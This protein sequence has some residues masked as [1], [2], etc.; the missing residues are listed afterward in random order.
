MPRL[1]IAFLMSFLLA[2]PLMGQR[3]TIDSLSRVLPSVQGTKRVDVLNDLSSAHYDYDSERGLE[4]ARQARSLASELNY[5]PGLRQAITYEGFYYF[6][7]GDFTRA[8]ELYRESAGVKGDPDEFQGYNLVMIGNVFRALAEYDSAK[9]NYDRAINVLA[10]MNASNDLAFAYKNLGRLYVMQWKNVD[11]EQSF[12]KALTLY[13]S[14][15]RRYGIADIYLDLAQLSLHNSD[16]SRSAKF[17][18]DGCKIAED[19]QHEYLKTICLLRRGELEF[20]LG[21]YADALRSYFEALG[22]LET[23][24]LT[25]LLAQLY[26]NIG[27]VYRAIGQNDVALKYYEESL[28]ISER[29][30]TKY[31]IARTYNSIAVIYRS[32]NK[33]QEA[34]EFVNKSLAIRDQIHDEHGA[35][36]SYNARGVIYYQAKNYNKALEDFG[37]AFAI[38]SKIKHRDGMS[39]TLYN[40]SLVYLDQKQFQKAVDY[41]MR[42]LA[43]E[44]SIGNKYS[45]GFS[46][47][48]LG[49]LYTQL[50]KFPQAEAHLNR[51]EKIAKEIRSN[52]L[53]MN[54]A[55]FWSQYFD[56]RNNKALA[57]SYYQL[58][59]SIHDSIYHDI[60]A[61]KLAELQALYQMEK[62]DQEIA[63][64]SQEKVNRE[65]EIQLQRS[66]IN[67][68]NIL[69]ASVITGLV[70]VSLLAY[71]TYR[72]SKRIRKANLSITEQKE[73]IQAQSEELMEASETIAEINRKLEVKIEERTQAL[74]QAYKELDTFFYRSSHDFRRPL[75]TFL[76][77][78]EVAKVT[79]KDKAALELF[80]KVRET[81]SNLDK[82]LVKLQSISDVGSQQLFYKEVFMKEIF[83]T[84]CDAF[85]D[86]LHRK[87]IK[88]SID[89]SLR[90]PFI[91]YPAMVR[92]IVE[93]LV[94]NAI[95]FSGVN[96]P[97][98]K[99]KVVENG[100]YI[101]I[102]FQDNGQ[103]IAKEYQEQVFDMYFRGNERS[104]G[105]GLGL[106]I[107]KKAVEKLDGSITLSS[108]PMVGSTF[109]VMLPIRK[110]LG[111]TSTVYNKVG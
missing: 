31:E 103:G 55:M 70:L 111:G 10:R 15:D 44:E 9:N 46:N 77:L 87:N 25:L 48:R 97:F 72:Y 83:D 63:L 96:H 18:D 91:S 36:M 2:L 30:G 78:A 89:V 101:T 27:E 39:S 79:V 105:N 13:Q 100:E 52:S 34:L 28:G 38:R 95:Y 99:V 32:Q 69:L 51:A 5:A 33:T 59:S 45:M 6:S 8:L 42:A 65:N 20:R 12:Q 17:V 57:L 84:V 43:I 81:A 58:Y 86:D 54:N 68:Q 22:A 85:R 37:R 49:N 75:T 94:E 61:Q 66:R 98:I 4:F 24:D 92:I 7:K 102:D 26:S 41:Q 74:S 64:L 3:K 16:Y 21:E 19:I 109:T 11:A 93:N 108:I 90:H 23:K 35:G 60:S 56:A 71:T 14:I 50:R 62:K 29:I 107:V 47:N 1:A 104:K 67:A 76:G 40:E 80:D 82:M 73:E 110:P 88:A 106:Y 53:L